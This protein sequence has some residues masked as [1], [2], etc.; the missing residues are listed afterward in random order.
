M[1]NILPTYTPPL[2]S[3]DDP[4]VEVAEWDKAIDSYHEKEYKQSLI[5]TLNYLNPDIL[6][7]K[8]LEGDIVTSQMQGSAEITLAI[9]D[10]DVTI[11]APFLRIT[12]K[13]NKVALLRKIAEINFTPLDL[14]QIYLEGD[15][16]GF[17]YKSPI[18]LAQPNKMYNILREIAFRADEYDDNFIEKYKAAFISEPQ[19][20]ALTDSEKE[21][22]WN[23]IE[24][25]FS[26]HQSYMQFF[27]KRRWEN[28]HWDILAISMLKISNMPYVNGTLRSELIDEV[29]RIFSSIFDF[30]NRVD[31]AKSF[32]K[33]LIARP[34]EE[35]MQQL[36]HAEQFSSMRWRSSP[37]IIQEHL[38]GYQEQVKRYQS[39]NDDMA[40][41]YFL[42]SLFLKMIYN[43][44]LEKPYKK[45]IESVLTKV[46]GKTPEDATPQLMELYKAMLEDE[47]DADDFISTDS[48][49]G[50]KGSYFS[51][52]I[53]LAGL[54]YIAYRAFGYFFHT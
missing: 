50:G 34:K 20:K 48:E 9:T 40:L 53:L 19:I 46:S 6:K 31:H 1:E 10:K 32:M 28:Y 45:S 54:I 12:E 35:I 29:N 47:L 2:K 8:A 3:I 16:V 49:S 17:Q 14:T 7:D 23:Q 21:A 39:N 44:N 27:T 13:T 41:A 30:N 18:E 25:I 52:F 51:R 36:Y 38:E 22:A 15:Q 5:H 43:Y 26:E 4:I 24:T 37:K 33:K 11:K 42:Q